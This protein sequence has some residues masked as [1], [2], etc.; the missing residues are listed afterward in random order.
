MEARVVASR[1]APGWNTY[2][3]LTGEDEFRWQ[4]LHSR[5]SNPLAATSFCFAFI[6]AGAA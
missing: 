6:L 5:P 4:V 3:P 2:G 1:Y